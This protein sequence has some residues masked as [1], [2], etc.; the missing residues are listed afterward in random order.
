[1]EVQQY[2]DELEGPRKPEFLELRKVIVDNLPK[3]FEECIGYGMIGYVVPHSIYP[4]GY[5]CTPKLPL[6]FINIVMRKDIITLYH[7][8]LYSDEKLLSWFKDEY[9]K[10]TSLKLDMG[11]SCI[12]FKKSGDIPF[13]LIVALIQKVSVNEWITRYEDKY[14]KVT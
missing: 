14:K 4:A 10:L 5:H 12:R 3:G 8:G 13:S 7:M 2:I 6:P 9:S 11:K 1:M